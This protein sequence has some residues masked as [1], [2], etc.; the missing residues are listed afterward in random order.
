MNILDKYSE[1]TLIVAPIAIISIA[2]FTF[3]F[4]G[5]KQDKEMAQLYI[6]CLAVSDDGSCEILMGY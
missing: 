3:T 1:L 6:D 4:L 2:I 5:H